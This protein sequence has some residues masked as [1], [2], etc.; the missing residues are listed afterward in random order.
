MPCSPAARPSPTPADCTAPSPT[1]ACGLTEK[2]DAT[3][4]AP[5]LL[6]LAFDLPGPRRQVTFCQLGVGL[7]DW[8]S[9]LLALWT[10]GG[11]LR[12]RSH[13]AIGRGML[14]QEERRQLLAQQA[15]HVLALR[16]RLQLIL[17]GL[18]KHAL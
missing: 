16:E 17:V 13:L 15:G 1:S 5:P 6:A 7:R 4:R 14:L 2:K 9:R 3:L 11:P 10:A 12:R 18:S 8:F